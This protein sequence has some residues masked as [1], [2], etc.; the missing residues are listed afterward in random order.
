M[1]QLSARLTSKWSGVSFVSTALGVVY[2]WFGVLKFFPG[3]SPAEQLA[4]A[5]VEELTMGWVEPATGL[6]LLAVW[7]VGIGLLLLTG[8]FKRWVLGA[9][10]VHICCTFTPLVFFPE[11]C[12]TKFPFGL[13]LVGQYIL[14]N[15]VFLG[16]MVVLLKRDFRGGLADPAL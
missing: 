16:V 4:G 10:L 8:S 9:A 5:T 15:L 14:K 1:K 7:E 2:L 13:T 11:M 12:F 6:V 3:L